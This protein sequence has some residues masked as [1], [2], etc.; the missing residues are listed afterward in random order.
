MRKNLSKIPTKFKA[1]YS[2]KNKIFNLEHATIETRYAFSFNP[3]VVDVNQSLHDTYRQII[4]VLSK[5]PPHYKWFIQFELSPLGRLHVHGEIN[6]TD[7]GKFYAYTIPYLCRRGATEIDTKDD[8]S[9]WANYCDKQGSIMKGLLEP[10]L[11]QY[12]VKST[13]EVWITK[14]NNDFEKHLQ[15]DFAA[16]AFQD[17]DEPLILSPPG[18]LDA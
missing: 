4:Y 3:L 1:N 11:L 7:I 5:A 18:D 8:T 14:Y 6:I 10:L 9:F 15:S 16:H 2:L 12:R 17:E 13:D